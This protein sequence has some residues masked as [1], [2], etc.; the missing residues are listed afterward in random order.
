MWS[1]QEERNLE[2][3]L[4][5]YEKEHPGITIR[6]LGAVNDDTKTI[7]ALVAGAPPD[8]FTLS[9]PAYLGVLAHN[10]AIRPLDD[11]LTTSGLKESDFVPASLR[12]C[13]YEKR[14]YG[15]PFL[16]D[17]AALMWDKQAFRE[18]GLDPEKPPR[19]VEE[20]ADYAV[21]LTKRDASGKITRL[22]LRRPDD[23]LLLFFLFGGHLTDPITGRITANDPGNVAGLTWYC[24][25]V[26]RLGGIEQINAFSSGFGSNQ[27]ANNPFFTGKV[28]MQ[29]DGEW[30]PYWVSRYAPQ[31]SYGVAPVPP[32]AAHPE[33]ARTT[34]IG[35]NVFCI[36]TDSKHAVEA[37]Q[38]LVWMESLEAQ[39]Q[40]AHDMNN[41]P[42][43][44]AALHSPLLREG[45]AFRRAYGKFCDLADSPNAAFF[46]AL[47]SASLYMNQLGNAT[48]R[49]L[50]GEATPEQAL[51]KVQARVQKEEDEQ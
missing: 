1:G 39:T 34:A 36:P 16:I 6:N 10:H 43:M 46:P 8:L 3:V 27:G 26:K 23:M 31:L 9:N 25:L 7:R 42:N 18:A 30:N 5:L 50:Y 2:R 48:D 20:L 12:L 37:A 17:D 33:R 32:P 14:L 51:A 22:G 28:A 35:G 49:V 11:L 4:R 19:T 40:F 45:T 15:M 38:F 21:K 13:R 29:I 44:R 47:P 24:D 41:V